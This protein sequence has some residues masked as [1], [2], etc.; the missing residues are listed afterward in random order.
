[1]Q[2]CYENGFIQRTFNW[3]AWAKA[4]TPYLN[5]ATFID[6]AKL[7]TCIKLIMD[8]AAAGDEFYVGADF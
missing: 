4:A 7:T 1:M 3:P 5:D 8:S 2:A 6:R